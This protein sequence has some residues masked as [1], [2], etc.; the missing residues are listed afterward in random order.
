EA[1]QDSAEQPR[2]VET[3]ARRGYRLIVPLESPQ[4]VPSPPPESLPA[5]P[6]IPQAPSSSGTPI[7][8]FRRKL[9]PIS[10]V[11]AALLC[12]GLIILLRYQKRS[13]NVAG[14]EI[15]SLAVLPLENLSQDPSQD[16]F[17]DGMTDAMITDLGKIG[18]LRVISRTSAMQYKR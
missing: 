9:L 13:A 6:A 17:A 8:M 10:S 2:Y 11:V 18:T 16:Y 7:S 3:I 4:P 1:L 5:L 12:A 14:A 15:H